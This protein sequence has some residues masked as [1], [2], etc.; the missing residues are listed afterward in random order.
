MITRVFDLPVLRT[1]NKFLGG[2]LGV[3]EGLVLA[4]FLASFTAL[5]VPLISGGDISYTEFS[6]QASN[7]ALF[8]Y[9]YNNNIITSILG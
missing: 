9:F 4:Y 3:V 8:S 5:L 6:S 2:L 7:S 1:I